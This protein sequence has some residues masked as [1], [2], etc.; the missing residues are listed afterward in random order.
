MNPLKPPVRPPGARPAAPA[1]LTI[2]TCRGRHERRPAAAVRNYDFRQSGFLAPG[3]L[4]QLR[5]RHEPFVSAFATRLA[6]FLCAEVTVRLAQVQVV[7]Y[8]Q[9][10]ASL[11][12]PAHIA[13]FKIDPLKG[14]GLLVVPPALALSLVDR[15]LG[16]PGQMT[17]T[18][19]ELSEIEVALIDQVVLLLLTEWCRHWSEI[20][21]LRPSL[22]AR[23]Y[24]ARFLRT[25]ADAAVLVLSLDAGFGEQ[26][27]RLELVFPYQTVEPLVRLL[28]SAGPGPKDCP[29]APS[30]PAKWDQRFDNVP[31]PV[32]A[33][34]QGLKLSAGDVARLQSGDVLMLDSPSAAPVLLRLGP[35]PK[36]VGRAGMSAGRWAV[37]LTG[38]APAHPELT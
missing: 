15:M 7:G 33:E 16:G 2:L 5:L 3:E 22:L 23:E 8:Q 17:D 34:W 38:P 37:E 20:R 6:N 10:T 36:F 11:P 31:V 25:T 27:E 19:R 32:A 4:R 9:Y 28:A 14:T 1:E 26:L 21:D 13:L 24:N 35:I 12:A 30:S 18:A 29:A